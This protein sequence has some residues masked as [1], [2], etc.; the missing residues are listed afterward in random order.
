MPQASIEVWLDEQRQIVCQRVVGAMDEHDFTALAEATAACVARLRDPAHVRILTDSRKMS[1]ANP[2][3]RRAG[4]AMFERPE[5]ERLA[6]WGGGPLVRV[7]VTFFCMASGK[8]NMRAFAT[9]QE[10]LDWLT[11]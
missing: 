8:Q 11:R 4:M 7:L 5:L 9:E 10:A 1:H 6:L 2:R 3:A